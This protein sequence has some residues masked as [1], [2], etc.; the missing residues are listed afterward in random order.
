MILDKDMAAW[1]PPLRTARDRVGR[2]VAI[3]IS[4]LRVDAEARLSN[5]SFF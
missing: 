5:K 4:T 1:V 3:N 2:S